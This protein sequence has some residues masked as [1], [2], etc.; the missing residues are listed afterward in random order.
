MGPITI[1]AIAPLDIDENGLLAE[2][3]ADT[4]LK[5]RLL[6]PMRSLKT[7]YQQLRYLLRKLLW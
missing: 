4:R 1:P 3:E 6:N 7:Q 5:K 2:I